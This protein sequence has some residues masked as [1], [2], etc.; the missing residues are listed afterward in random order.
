LNSVDKR[1]IVRTADLCDLL[2]GQHQ[3]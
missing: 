1:G 3:A 2:M